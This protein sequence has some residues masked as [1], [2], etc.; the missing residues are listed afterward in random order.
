[1]RTC[2]TLSPKEA[3]LLDHNLWSS[4]ISLDGLVLGTAF[5]KSRANA[6]VA[7]LLAQ[8]LVETG[9]ERRRTGGRRAEILR[10][11]PSLGVL[12]AVAMTEAKS[13]LRRAAR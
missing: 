4:G 1:M 11:A 5:P 10:L 12:V 9:D 7:G 8:G 2:T 13:P 3:M 6:S